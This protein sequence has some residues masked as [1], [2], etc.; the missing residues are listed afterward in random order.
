MNIIC[1]DTEF[2]GT[3]ERNEI[4]ELSVFNG[5]GKEIYHQLFKPERCRQWKFTEQIHGITPEMVADKP[6]FKSKLPEMQKLFDDADLIVG[7]A[8]END[9][10]TLAK[11]GIKGL[12][13]ERCLDV[14]HLYWA[15]RGE[16][17]EITIYS[18]PN[19]VKCAT[20]CGFDWENAKA[21]SASA[22]ALAT[23]Q[24]YHV[25]L[26]E[27]A[28]NQDMSRDGQELKDETIID[29]IEKLKNMVEKAMSDHDREAAKGYIY[30][31]KK[32][33]VHIMVARHTEMEPEVIAKKDVK[34][35]KLIVAI[36][37]E[38]RWRGQYDM[39]KKFSRKLVTGAKHNNCWTLSDKDINYF[40]NYTNEYHCDS[41]LYKHMLGK[42]N[43]W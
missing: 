32:G 24:C 6:S 9:I 21:H 22:D 25:L 38:D 1:L 18:V 34:G 41:K 12:E 43:I 28:Q 23:L 39:Q 11:S 4:L 10:K 2:T 29:I 35:Q 3:M 13:E 37:V 5:D 26:K 8:I 42:G 20:D 30:L 14:R 16:A 27:F 33:N 17:E 31:F 40:K 19:L 15:N 7:F 36:Q